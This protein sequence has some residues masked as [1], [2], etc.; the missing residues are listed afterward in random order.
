[1]AEVRLSKDFTEIEKPVSGT[2]ITARQWAALLCSLGIGLPFFFVAKFKFHADITAS[3]LTMLFISMPIGFCILYKK[4]G[5]Y[6]DKHIRFFVETYFIRNTER[7]YVTQNIYDLLTQEEELKKEV[8]RI[9]FKGK[10]PEQIQEI[11][12]SGDKSEVRIGKKKMIIPMKGPINYQTKKELEKAVK[13][14]KLKGEI[15]QSA[16]ETIPYEV[17]HED[18]IFESSPGYFTQTIAYED[19]TYQLL[20]PE[21]K[22]LVFGRW[23]SLINFFDDKV[24]FQ[25]CFGNMEMNKEEYSRDFMI[26]PDETDT[27]LIRAARKEYSDMQVKQFSK[28]TNN[29]KKVRYLTYGVKAIDYKAAQRQLSK[30]TKQ[31]EKYFKRLGSKSKVLSGYDRLELLYKLFHPGTK[32]KLLWNFDMLVKTGLSSKDFIAPS[33]FSFRPGEGFNATKY[34]KYGDRIGAAS[35]IH[36]NA[37]DMSDRIVWDMLSINSNIWISIHGDTFTKAESLK[38]AK[39]HVSDIQEMITEKQQ[40]AVSKGYDMDYLPAELKSSMEDADD[41][42]RDIKRADEK[43]INTTIT[44]V[45]TASTKKELDD[46]LFELQGILEGFGCKLIRLDNRQ[47]QGF[48]SALPLGNNTVEVKRTFITKDIASFIPFTTKELYSS[49]GQYYGMNA[50]SNNVIMED[51]KKL[52]NPNSL[53]LGMPGFGKTFAVKREIFDVFLKTNDHLLIIDPEGEYKWL[54]RLLGGQVIKIALN[55]PLYINPMEISLSLRNEEDKEYDPIAA[56]CNFI[57]SLSEQILGKNGVLDKDRI[58]VI[59]RACKNVYERYAANPTPENMPI[60]EDL[61]HELINMKGEMKELGLN[62]SVALSR[63]VSGS[64]SYFNHKSNVNIHSRLVCFDLKDMDANQR[65]L[66]MLIIQEALW[67]RVKLNRSRGIYTR[68]YMDEFHLFLRY[69]NTAAYSVEMW[70]R[71]RKWGGIPTGITQNI[72]DLFRSQEIQNILDTTN[73]IMMLNQAGDDA[74]IL[75]EHLDLSGEEVDHI[76]TGE[77]GK[78]LLWVEGNKVP[79]EDDFPENTLC[80]KVMTTKPEE[81]IRKGNTRIKKAV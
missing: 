32:D 17:P 48:M 64:L 1:M 69:P 46:N 56:K 80:Y 37:N 29:L 15:P 57:V 35:Y 21:P 14:A 74:R 7:P 26:M 61:Y 23:H 33:S 41:L 31:L 52:V 18:G 45:Q 71:F 51:K 54:V 16:Q 77:P 53:V 65:D 12:A 70:K 3:M 36:I 68:T 24:H 22:E 9:I 42:F 30:I 2:G 50:L 20:D 38:R 28:G 6:L 49:K 76:Q 73:F 67:D 60:L 47:E 79:F 27:N 40:R 59:D 13:K 34:F 72:K 55:S 39:N 43:M 81:A 25:H 10:S 5:L 11:K 44:V 58:G 63:Y 66:A 8:E 78:G 19:I 4:D 75:A 62:L